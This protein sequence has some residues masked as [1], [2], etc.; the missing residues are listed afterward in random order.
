MSELDQ[1]DDQARGRG[2]AAAGFADEADH[3]ALVDG[4]RNIVDRAH[5][6]LGAEQPAADIEML[7]QVLHLQQR[8]RRAADVAAPVRAFQLLTSIALRKPSLRRLK[9]IE[10]MKIITPGKR[11][12]PW[13]D[14]DRGAQ[15]V[16]HQ[17]PFRLR[18]LGAEAEKRQA[19]REDHA[20]ADQA[21]RIDEDRSEHVAEHMHAA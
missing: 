16:Q 5:D 14:V 3:L 20:D 2:F 18:R 19:G 17:A 13:I 7:D 8:L 4:D 9:Q 12:D 21:R 10:T 15:R 6:A 1:A 11:R